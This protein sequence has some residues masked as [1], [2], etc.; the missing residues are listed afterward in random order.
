MN[1]LRWKQRKD[2]DLNTE[3]QTHLDEAIRERMERGELAE[4]ARLNA[5][6]EFGNVGL[7]KEVTHA[8]WGWAGLEKLLQDLRYGTRRLIKPSGFTLLAVLALIL[9]TGVGGWNLMPSSAQSNVETLKW[10]YAGNDVG[11]NT[12]RTFPDGRFESVSEEKVADITIHSK[13]TGKITDGLL[14]EYELVNNKGG[15]EAKVT[16]KAGKA[17]ITEEGKTREV[18]FKP[19]KVFF[20]NEHPLLTET[21]LRAIDP[22]KEGLQKIDLLVLD[23]AAPEKVELWKKGALTIERDGN[24]TLINHYLAYFPGV[25]ID[26]YVTPDRRFVSMDAPTQNWRAVK[27]GYEDLIGDPVSRYPE[28]SQPTLKTTVAQGVKIRMRDGVELVADII[29][30]ADGEPHPAI[31]RRTPYGREGLSARDGA[32]WA[33][34]GY[35]LIVQDVRGR[36]DSDGEWQ[37]FVNERKDGYDTI[38]WIAKQAWSSGKVGMIGGSYGGMVQWAAA[39]EAPP[40]LKCIVPQVS[41]TDSF[42]NIPLDHGVPDLY[43]LWWAS[44]VREKKLP[45]RPET[46]D[47]PE[48]LL[49]LPLSKLDDEVLGHDIPFFNEWWTKETPSAFS[50]GFMNDL[51]KVKIPVLHISGWWDG[52]GIGTKLHWAKL[53]AA[54]HRAQWLIYGPWGHDFNSSTSHE[55]VDYGPDAVMELDSLYL[56]WFDTWLKDKQVGWEKQPRVRAFVTGANQWR[57][58]DDWPDSQ[59]EPL[60]FY[61]SST[62]RANGVTG[63]GKLLLAPPTKSE[64]PDQYVYDPA[65]V[66]LTEE[67]D[68]ATIELPG[69]KKDLLVYRTEPLSEA[70][71]LAGP[72]E[73]ELYFATNVKDT[74]FFASLVAVDEKGA[75]HSIGLPGKIRARYLSGW[76]TPSLLERGKTYKAVI[77]LWD[78]A[79]RLE[80]GQRL[81]LIIRSELFPAYARNLNT[82][83]SNATATR[84][85]AATQTIYHDA[86][87]PSALRLRRLK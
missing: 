9:A 74:D 54:G 1:F 16:A 87:R 19:A 22:N 26:L 67:M 20:A 83:E 6:R 58:L 12:Y 34:R 75:L 78:T 35:A 73:L 31:L 32:W 53:R 4:E 55:D 85:V 62:G 45:A 11:S 86:K 28:L 82:G 7:V 44:Y 41:P 76:D 81:G 64:K 59:S 63:G 79:H 50:G 27:A 48:K 37:P 13:L 23:E 60:T 66:K 47:N 30:P 29:R 65:K 21:L 15:S 57:E 24:K 8:T 77:A 84:M 49:T 2:E 72:I 36:N 38:D 5:Q 69:D 46:P 43:A 3:I 61:L 10:F 14:T 42:F 56:R 80:K 17:Q 52:D 33:S 39:V 70:L 40:A 18:D 25:P 71:D 68:L 51:G